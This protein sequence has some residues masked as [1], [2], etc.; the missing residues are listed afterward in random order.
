MP[1]DPGAGEGRSCARICA[2]GTPALPGG[3]HLDVIAFPPQGGSDTGTP[4]ASLKITP[5][6]RGSRR[7]GGARSRAGGGQTRCPRRV[8]GA[9]RA[10]PVRAPLSDYSGTGSRALPA[11]AVNRRVRLLTHAS[12][13]R[14]RLGRAAGETGRHGMMPPPGGTRE[15]RQWKCHSR[16]STAVNS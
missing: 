2:G 5:P 4:Y 1:V 11:P 9:A 6:L 10:Q 13:S 12:P 16:G 7:E 8:P 3:R 14:F 15:E